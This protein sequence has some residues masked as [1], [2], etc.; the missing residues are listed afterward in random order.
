MPPSRPQVHLP[1]IL[2]KFLTPREAIYFSSC[3]IQMFLSF[4]MGATERVLLGMMAFD[5]YMVICNPLRYLEIMSKSAYIP[6]AASS[7]VAGSSTTMVQT[8]LAM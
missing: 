4:A 3:A 5:H 7:W 1:L 6:M 8:S 2:D